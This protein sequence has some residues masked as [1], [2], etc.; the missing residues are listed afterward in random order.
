MRR[1]RRRWL[2]RCTTSLLALVVSACLVELVGII[3]LHVIRHDREQQADAIEGELEGRVAFAIRSPETIPDPYL[4]Y[5]LLPNFQSSCPGESRSR[6]SWTVRSPLR[7]PMNHCQS[8][9]NHRGSRVT[10]I[11]NPTP[12]KNRCSNS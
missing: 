12:T 3:G 8:A 7:T 9:L 1:R 2:F 5:R 11:P 10:C 6:T 4:F